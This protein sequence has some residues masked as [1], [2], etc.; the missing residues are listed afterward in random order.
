[1]GWEKIIFLDV[2][3]QVV[4]TNELITKLKLVKKDI[5]KNSLLDTESNV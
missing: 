3:I 2:A 1:M 4:Y 5:I